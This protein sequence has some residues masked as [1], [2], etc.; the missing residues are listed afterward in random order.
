MP[1][2]IFVFGSNPEGRHGMGAAKAAL[3]MGAVYG[4]G[5]GR[6][7][8]TYA[9]PTKNISKTLPY[10][11]EASGIT[12]KKSG[13]N[14]ISL[15]MISD[16]ILE[17]YRHVDTCPNDV[18]FVAYKADSTTLNGYSTNDIFRAFTC[19]KKVPDNVVFHESFRKMRYEP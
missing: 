7:G 5:R 8:N 3:S 19:G 1:N 9:L 15:G 14:S 6:V 13:K 4:I 10:Y 2:W 11:E 16:N 12:Y 18:F 17:L